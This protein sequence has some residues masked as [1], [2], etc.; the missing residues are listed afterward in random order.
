MDVDLSSANQEMNDELNGE[1]RYQVNVSNEREIEFYSN[2]SEVFCSTVSHSGDKKSVQ[3][4]ELIQQRP[5]DS[6]IHPYSSKLTK[7]F[8]LNPQSLLIVTIQGKVVEVTVKF[9]SHTVGF[10]EHEVEN[11][12]RSGS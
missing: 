11:F 9:L 1:N 8:D 5:E 7:V 12:S 6:K 10:R 4:K 3:G 2:Y